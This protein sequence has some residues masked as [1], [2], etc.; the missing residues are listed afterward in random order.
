MNLPDDEFSALGF[1]IDRRQ[2]LA[3]A[4]AGAFLASPSN[5]SALAAALGVGAVKLMRHQAIV[6]GINETNGQAALK[7]AV[8]DAIS[9]VKWLAA[10][11]GVEPRNIILFTSPPL[12][13]PPIPGVQLRDATGEKIEK[14]ITDLPRI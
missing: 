10:K 8:K 1:G 9:V 3:A 6:I 2:F 11:A 14:T 12:N 4:S 7:H 13:E 5:D